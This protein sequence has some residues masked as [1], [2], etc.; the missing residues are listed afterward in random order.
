MYEQSLGPLGQVDSPSPQVILYGNNQSLTSQGCWFA[1]GT[2]L[3]FFVWSDLFCLCSCKISSY[4][5]E[6]LPK[7][8]FYFVVDIFG[9]WT[10][11]VAGKSSLLAHCSCRDSRYCHEVLPQLLLSCVFPFPC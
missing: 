1:E 10:A 2:G 3:V 8:V 7:Q 6:V 4:F 5:W 11:L 9:Q